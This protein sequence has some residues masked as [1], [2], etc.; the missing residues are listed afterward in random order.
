M[1]DFDKEAEREKLRQQYE[2]E[3][4][5]RKSTQRMSEL[6][7]QGA[8]MTG[9]HCDTCGDPIFRYDGNEFCP[10]CQQRNPNREH[11][12]RKRRRTNRLERIERRSH[13]S[14]RE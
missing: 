9:K 11:R 8:T 6:L 1:S 4:E 12:T 10:T 3:K 5:E 13:T 2:N 7:L 14:K